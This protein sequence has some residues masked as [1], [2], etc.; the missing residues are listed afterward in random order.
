MA[1]SRR[2]WAAVTGAAVVACAS[3]AAAAS[4][5]GVPPSVLQSSSDTAAIFAVADD[6]VGTGSLST[7]VADTGQAWTVTTGGFGIAAGEVAATSAPAPNQAHVTGPGDSY[8]ASVQFYRPWS[9]GQGGGLWLNGDAAGTTGVWVLWENKAGGSITVTKFVS[10][11]ET[12]LDTRSGV[13]RPTDPAPGTLAVAFDAVLGRYTVMLDSYPSY[14]VTLSSADAALLTPNA[15]VG[16]RV[17]SATA[18]GTFRVLA[19]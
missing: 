1:M 4:L 7:H 18:M 16:L 19:Q 3:P 9:R 10:G 17:E 5:G 8:I 13:G 11:V 14:T 2:A 15:R 6:F 12:V